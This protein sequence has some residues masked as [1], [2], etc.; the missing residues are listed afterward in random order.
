MKAVRFTE[1]GGGPRSLKIETIPD[2]VPAAGEILVRVQRAAFN[3]RD[4]FITQG[5]Y[6][7]IEI[8]KTLGSDGAGVV[9]AL[10]EGV[11]GPAPGTPVVIDP[12]LGWGDDPHVWQAGASVLGMPREGTFAQLITIP[13][14]NVHPKPAHLSAEEAAAIP[15]AGLTAYRA[16][17]TRGQLRKGETILITGI[18]GGVQSFVLL[19]AKHAGAHAIVTSTKDAK[20]ER[21]KALGA[22]LTINT[23]SEPDWHRQLR[24]SPPDIVVDSLGGEMLAR[25]LTVVKPGGRV[26][27]YG[28]TLGDATIKPFPV[29]WNHVDLRGTSMGAPQDFKGMLKLFDQGLRPAIDRVYPM[30]QAGEAAERLSGSEQFG[31]I[32]LTID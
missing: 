9:E 14:Q 2:P 15:L 30:E 6:P 25:C 22:D 11:S 21:A 4:V 27:I 16:V 20:L 17:F 28:G 12:M 23:Q 31:K 18:G 24:K 5:L 26:V 29:F 19:F 32:I 13:A 7:G 3:R 1:K 8:P 10:G